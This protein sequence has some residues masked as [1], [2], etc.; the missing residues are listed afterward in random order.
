LLALLAHR[1]DRTLQG[2][3]ICREPALTEPADRLTAT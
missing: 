3:R 2:R 1:Y